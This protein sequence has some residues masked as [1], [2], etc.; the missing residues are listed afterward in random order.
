M[1]YKELKHKEQTKPKVNTEEDIIKIRVDI[2]EIKTTET[3]ENINENKCWFFKKIK[4]LTLNQAL[5]EE[6]NSNQK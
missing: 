6:K 5:E 3:I 4:L 2:N 1:H